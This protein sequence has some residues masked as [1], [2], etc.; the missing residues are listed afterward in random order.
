MNPLAKNFP[1]SSISLDLS[2]VRVP[3]AELKRK[4]NC[5][6]NFKVDCRNKNLMNKIETN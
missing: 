6:L 5:S 4:E 2:F 3:H 1:I